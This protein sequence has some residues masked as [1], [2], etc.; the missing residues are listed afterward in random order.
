MACVGIT[1]YMLRESGRYLEGGILQRTFPRSLW[2]NITRRGVHPGG[3]SETLNVLT[4]ERT[5]PYTATPEWT[6]VSV[7]DGAEGGACLPPVTKIETGSTQRS[8]Q[9]YRRALEGPDFC[10]EEFR[11]VFALTER[12][13]RLT[14]SF[15]NHVGIEWE[16]R[17]RNEYFRL[18]K[19]KVIVD[20]CPPTQDTDMLATWDAVATAQSATCPT[21]Q[22]TQGILDRYRYRLIRDGATP[23]AHSSTGAPVLGLISSAETL[24]G[25]IRNNADVREDFRWAKPMELL[26]AM[27][28]S[29]EYRGFIHMEDL[30]PNRYECNAG[31]YTKVATFVQQAATIGQKA[32][33]N[34]SWETAT[35]EESYIH[36]RS[37]FEQLVPQ[38][39]VTPGNKFRFNPIN[40]LGQM[41]VQNIR[42]RKCNPDGN[43]LYHRMIMA[44]S[45]KPEYPEH[46]VAFIHLRCDPACNLIESCAT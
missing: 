42:D 25:L 40:Y 41:Q 43:I 37:V 5:A 11:T 31:T 4:V 12:L 3:L 29:R 20:G 30:Y 21:S 6:A 36:S 23:V 2:L 28:I 1:D 44:A 14:D 34:T 27:G 32:E 45:S 9:L 35:N 33:I 16:M 38:P 17:D 26:A 15:S 18:A 24:D 13:N 22:L 8:F 39:I 46:G 7:N 10:A 19:T